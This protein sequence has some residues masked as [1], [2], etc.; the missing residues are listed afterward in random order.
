MGAAA[1]IAVPVHGEKRHI[2]EHVKLAQDRCKSQ[3][4]DRAQERRS[5]PPGAGPGRLDR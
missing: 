1:S 4:T 5:D 3:S 2:R